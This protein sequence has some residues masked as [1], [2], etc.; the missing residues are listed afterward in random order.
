MVL[1]TK[2][3]FPTSVLIAWIAAWPVAIFLSVFPKTLILD[4]FRAVCE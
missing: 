1:V 2:E 4:I 3:D